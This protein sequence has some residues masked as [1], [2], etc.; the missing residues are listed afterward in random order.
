MGAL[1]RTACDR[2]CQLWTKGAGKGC[3]M[4]GLTSDS[5]DVIDPS[6]NRQATIVDT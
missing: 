6:D 3:K 1:L 2:V 4:M 5:K